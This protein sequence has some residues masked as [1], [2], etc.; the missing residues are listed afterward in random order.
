MHRRQTECPISLWRSR[1]TLD[2]HRPL[3]SLNDVSRKQ[4]CKSLD[5][6]S[7]GV[8]LLEIRLWK[9][10]QTYHGPQ[11]TEETFRDKGVA[12]SLV[13]NLGSKTRWL[14][15]EVVERCLCA[16]EDL[17]GQKGG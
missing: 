13:P 5:I 17:S 11:Y 16:R 7:L 2:L 9:D 4:Y 1:T 10:Q 14:Y 12:H 8:V 15:R 3:A 6:E